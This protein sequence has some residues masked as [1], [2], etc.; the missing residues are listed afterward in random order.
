[1]QGK[2]AGLAYAQIVITLLDLTAFS[3]FL[4]RFNP[5]FHQ[6]KKNMGFFTAIR[7]AE[8]HK[9]DILFSSFQST[10]AAQRATYT[11]SS[12]RQIVNR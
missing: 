6:K 7:R 4:S 9:I 2:L 12:R 3:A 5:N 10:P 11:A 8:L 1:M